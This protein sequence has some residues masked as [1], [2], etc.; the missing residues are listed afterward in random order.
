MAVDL[1]GMDARATF[2]ESGLKSG[3]IIWP[4]GH[5]LRITYLQYLIAFCGRLEVTSDVVSNRFVGPFVPDSR[6]KF[7]AFISVSHHG[8]QLIW[9][10]FL[11]VP[12][13]N[14]CFL[15]QTLFPASLGL[16]LF[17]AMKCHCVHSMAHVRWR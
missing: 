1:V 14:S 6:V 8:Y 7:E 11:I 2:G 10:V 15:L 3:R 9:N 4:A 17:L 12:T 5:V 16:L 13:C